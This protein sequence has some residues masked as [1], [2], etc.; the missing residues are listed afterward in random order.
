MK[1]R[2]ARLGITLCLSLIVPALAQTPEIT[3][4]TTASTSSA[5]I[6]NVYVQVA[7]GVN[8][9]NA[10]A[11]GKLTLVKGSPFAVSGQMEGH[12]GKYLISVGTTNLHTYAIGSTGS[13]GKQTASVNTQN[14]DGAECGTTSVN[15]SANGAVLDHTGKFLYV[16]LFGAQYQEGNTT[17]ASWQ[18]YQVESNG[19]LNFLNSMEY[20][21]WADGSAGESTVPTVS[22]N[23]HFA[24]G[25]FDWEE[26][27]CT[28]FSTFAQITGGALEINNTANIT[29]PVG[30]PTGP[31]YYF[32]LQL[33]ADPT[34][35]LAVLMYSEDD[36]PFGNIG[37]EQLASYT[38]NNATGGIVSTNTWENMPIPALTNITDM[39]M[40]PSGKLLALAGNGL[41]IFHFNGAAP[42]TEYSSVLL[43]SITVDQLGWD[44]N[45]HLYALSYSAQKLYVYMVTPTSITAV[46]GSPYTVSGAYG[47]NG[48]IVVPK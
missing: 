6:A 40:S 44:N 45:N 35:H 34:N 32:P 42:I 15:D 14:Y 29:G 46:A 17:C 7:K 43:P 27:C 36:L 11:A 37:P 9:Y 13:V 39:N 18:S 20:E 21:S 41:Q 26:Y 22:G 33:K 16:Q 5:P 28:V 31:W 25:V 12:N 30:D 48:L 4:G 1:I 38:I 8:V 24:Y 47:R 3:E 2:A 10:T 19:Q 23:D